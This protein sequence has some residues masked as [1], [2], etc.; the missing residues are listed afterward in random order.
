[1]ENYKTYTTKKGELIFQYPGYWLDE[2]EDEDTY[3]FFE[4]YLGSFRINLKRMPAKGFNLKAYLEKENHEKEEFGP[5]W[6]TFNDVEFLCYE[7]DWEHNG[8]ITHIHYYISGNKNLLITCTFAYD[9]AVIDDVVGMDEIGKELKGVEKLL[10]SII[11][12]ED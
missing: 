9:S 7:D 6:K 4:E 2:M 5:E 10:S 11:F 8:R 1:M 12:M 3:L